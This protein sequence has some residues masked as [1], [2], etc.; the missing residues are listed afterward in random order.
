MSVSRESNSCFPPDNQIINFELT[1]Q[2][3]GDFN[4]SLQLY[5]KGKLD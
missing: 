5:L 4:T 3:M 2:Q 1:G